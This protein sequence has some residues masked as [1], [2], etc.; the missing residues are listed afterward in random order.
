MVTISNPKAIDLI[1]RPDRAFGYITGTIE[2]LG[3]YGGEGDNTD[4]GYV[5]INSDY[6]RKRIVQTSGSGRSIY[7]ERESLLVAAP[8]LAH[9]ADRCY[10]VENVLNANKNRNIVVASLSECS[11]F[12][13]QRWIA[14]I[15]Y[16]YVAQYGDQIGLVLS[17]NP[18]AGQ[19]YRIPKIRCMTT[20][21]NFV[22]LTMGPG[23]HTY[24]SNV[25][26]YWITAM[27]VPPTS[28]DFM[29]AARRGAGIFPVTDTNP[30]IYTRN[31]SN[32]YYELEVNLTFAQAG[33]MCLYVTP[34][35]TSERVYLEAIIEKISGGY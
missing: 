1:D 9:G 30:I 29:L 8:I 35:N 18:T 21:D 15:F 7:D 16:G 25:P 17:F 32:Q 24:T 3:V 5:R 26:T 19:I 28:Y 10:P 14:S 23:Y 34:N 20:A 22:Y 33:T 12:Q 6:P 31:Q 11:Q 13:A 4:M 27:T 2:N